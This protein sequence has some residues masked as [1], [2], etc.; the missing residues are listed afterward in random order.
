MDL[1]QSVT[2]SMHT[3]S[4]VIGYIPCYSCMPSKPVVDGIQDAVGDLLG[5][6]AGPGIRPANGRRQRIMQSRGT[7]ALGETQA[8][9]AIAAG[10]TAP[11]SQHRYSLAS[12]IYTSAVSLAATVLVLA[13]NQEL[14]AECEHV[15]QSAA[16]RG[17]ACSGHI[18]TVYLCC[19]S[20]QCRLYAMF[21]SHPAAL[22]QKVLWMASASLLWRRFRS[23]TVITAGCCNGQPPCQVQQHRQD[24]QRAEQMLP[25]PSWKACL[26]ASAG[27]PAKLLS[28]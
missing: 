19:T 23:E 7:R 9:A 12:S 20:F 24:W 16:Q 25:S 13:P 26:L 15:V 2:E 11:S 1:Q 21:C 17:L 10:P 18:G 28:C 14:L 3:V 6:M 4:Q 5:G 27:L 22:W 8:V